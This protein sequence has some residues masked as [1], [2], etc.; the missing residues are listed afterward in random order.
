M[1]PLTIDRIKKAK[2]NVRIVPLTEDR[3]V[4][5]SKFAIQIKESGAW[6]NV[7]VNHDRNLCEKAVRQATNQV[8]LG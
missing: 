1:S 7:F 5:V 8:I 2:T 6:V 3:S 4:S